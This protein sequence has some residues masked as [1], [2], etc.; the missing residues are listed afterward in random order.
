MHLRPTIRALRWVLPA[1]A[2][3]VLAGAQPGRMPGEYP[4]WTGDFA[5]FSA[6]VLFGG[7]SAGLVQ[8]ARG[9]SFR[10]G[11]TRG[12]LGGAGVYAGKRIAVARWNGAGFVA[13]QVGSV[14]S[15]VVW[16]AGAGRPSFETVALPVGPVRFYL[17]TSGEG[18]RVQARVDAVAVASTVYAATRPELDWDPAS[19][20]SSGVAVFRVPHHSLRV[21]GSDVG[22]VTYPGVVVLETAGEADAEWFPA[23]FGHERVHVL[24][25]DQAFL[26]LGR[27]AQD[28]VASRVPALRQL[29]RWLDIDV[30]AAAV[31]GAGKLLGAPWLSHP[32]EIEALY[33]SGT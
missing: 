23:I 1:L 4:R 2:F 13:R 30:S 15:S 5:V 11:F 24:Q 32:W 12:A 17:R 33:L 16:N 31:A 20:L 21:G 7:V 14:A 6:N 27:P 10:D 29:G 8:S 28:A 9:G 19:S 22:G 18:P 25:I 3:P 26:A